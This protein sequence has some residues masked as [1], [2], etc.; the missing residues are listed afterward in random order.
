M[1]PGPHDGVRLLQAIQ[2][3]AQGWRTVSGRFRA[4]RHAALLAEAESRM[5]RRLFDAEPDPDRPGAGEV[6]RLAGSFDARRAPWRVRADFTPPGPIDADGTP[7]ETAVAHNNA[8]WSL[9]GGEVDWGHTADVPV[10][11]LLHGGPLS[12]VSAIAGTRESQHLGRR[13]LAVEGDDRPDPTGRFGPGPRR[14]LADLVTGIVL[15]FEVRTP[16]GIL[17]AADEITALQVDPPLDPGR[18]DPPSAP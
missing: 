4:T 13:V 12:E 15:R 16:D 8:Y 11:W 7:I 5:L 2:R 9:A 1:E 10:E 17:M 14:V 6:Q 18:F 3:E